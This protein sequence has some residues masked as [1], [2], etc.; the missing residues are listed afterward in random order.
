M[1]AKK[2]EHIPIGITH[3]NQMVSKVGVETKKKTEIKHEGEEDERLLRR[4]ATPDDC[5]ETIRKQLDPARICSI[6]F[7]T[8][9][10]K[11][12]MDFYRFA[13]V[14]SVEDT[15][16]WSYNGGFSLDIDYSISFTK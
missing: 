9:G 5:A 1:A 2:T 7:A 11:H 3:Q 4:W 13:F 6:F 15:G 14:G 12:R 10:H 8:I 16:I